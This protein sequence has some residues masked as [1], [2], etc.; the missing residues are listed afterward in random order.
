MLEFLQSL[1]GWKPNSASEETLSNFTSIY[2]TNKRLL[3]SAE[4]G[5]IIPKEL[6]SF[7]GR[8]RAAAAMC[9]LLHGQQLQGNTGTHQTSR[10]AFPT[11]PSQLP[12]TCSSRLPQPE[13]LWLCPA[14]PAGI[15]S[16]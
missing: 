16:H 7:S 5:S 13:K 8:P 2:S 9:C 3:G 12:S 11:A 10:A 1:V 14:V 6:S 4:R 15:F